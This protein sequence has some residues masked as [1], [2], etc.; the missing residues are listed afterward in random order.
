[1]RLLQ[2]VLLAWLQFLIT[3]GLS[4]CAP[5]AAAAISACASNVQSPP[6]F[7][8]SPDRNVQAGLAVDVLRSAV[9]M[10]KET[11]TIQVLPWKRCLKLTELGVIDLA[12]NVPT[13][14]IDPA[15]Y[16]V[17]D[18]YAELDSMYI[19]SRKQ[20][21]KGIP[22]SNLEDLKSFRICGLSGNT[23]D[24]YG[25]RGYPVDSGTSNYFSIVGKMHQGRCDI[26]LEKRQI[27]DALSAVDHELHALFSSKS[28]LV[29]RLPEDSPIGLHFA[30]S[31]RRAGAA[32]LLASLNQVI[33][34]LKK[35]PAPPRKAVHRKRPA[36]P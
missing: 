26:F 3:L 5:R 11:L 8:V 7:H 36:Q 4:A 6:Y 23:Y 13:A 16:L 28:L 15:P 1:M 20:W 34:G 12:L 25:L 30:I 2:P 24:S 10:L 14:Q 31:K 17:S 19:V 35:M 9:A 33:A 27:I 21:P 32:E 29:T 18:A 22:I